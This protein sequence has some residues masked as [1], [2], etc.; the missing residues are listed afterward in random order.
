MKNKEIYLT[1]EEQVYLQAIVRKGVHNSHVITRARVLLML[2]R[3]GKSDHVRY[4]RTAEY[5][6]ISVQAVY[7]MRDEFLANHDVESYL[8]RKKR[9]T[10]PRAPKLD[11]IAEAKII[12]LACSKPPE[13]YSR[14]TVRLLAEKAVELNFAEDISHMLIHR[15]LKK[16]NISLI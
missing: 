12:A 15:L 9:E 13:G 10:P 2:D 7:N 16:R 11:G 8:T 1:S 6:D 14:W 5:A 3:T 4:K